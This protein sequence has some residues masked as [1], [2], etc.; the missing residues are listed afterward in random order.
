MAIKLQAHPPQAEIRLK[1]APQPAWSG[2][3]RARNGRCAPGG[4]PDC[5][6][7]AA[8]SRAR[9]RCAPPPPADRDRLR[10]DVRVDGAE[11][12]LHL[13]RGRRCS[14]GLIARRGLP[15]VGDV[16]PR[17]DQHHLDAELTRLRRRATP[18]SPRP[19]ISMRHR[20]SCRAGRR[21]QTS[22]DTM[23]M[24]PERC[25]RNVGSSSRVSAMTPNRLVSITRRSSASGISSKAPPAATPALCTTA[26]RKPSV[27]ASVSATPLRDRRCIRHVELHDVDVAARRPTVPVPLRAGPCVPGCASWR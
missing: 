24:R 19:P 20:S 12:I 6:S 17:L 15:D 7:A 27:M 4:R 14:D 9:G 5:G 11:Q 8:A 22:L 26:S 2:I 1:S 16:R 13:R 3:S 25:L 23:T 21:A 10:G 18:P